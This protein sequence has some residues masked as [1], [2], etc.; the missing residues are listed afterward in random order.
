MSNSAP[1]MSAQSATTTPPRTV[2]RRRRSLPIGR[3]IAMTILTVGALGMIVPFVWMFITSLKSAENAYDLRP[4]GFPR[5]SYAENYWRA[6]NGPL[7]LLTNMYNSA[8]IAIA[9]TLALLITAP[10]AGYA[11]ARLRFRGQNA[12]FVGLLASLMVPVRS[13]SFRCS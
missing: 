10:L 7:P 4:T 1:V 8:F 12:L 3:I 11:F 9:T 2:T 5:S 13:P 6:I